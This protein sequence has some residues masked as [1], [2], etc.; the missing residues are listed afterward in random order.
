ME[1]ALLFKTVSR[2]FTSILVARVLGTSLG[3]VLGSSASRD[4]L[5]GYL[6][7]LGHL[8]VKGIR[9]SREASVPIGMLLFLSVSKENVLR[10]ED[11]MVKFSLHIP[12]SIRLPS[13]PRP[14]CLGLT[15]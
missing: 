6:W 15:A 4:P 9:P 1:Q 13:S 8:W 3:G 5:Q 2:K 7:E 10:K 12:A 11:G 14:L